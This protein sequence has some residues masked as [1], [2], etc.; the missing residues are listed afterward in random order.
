MDIT[1]LEDN[2]KNKFESAQYVKIIIAKS[3]TVKGFNLM[4]K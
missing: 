3:N 1:T 4:L 2:R